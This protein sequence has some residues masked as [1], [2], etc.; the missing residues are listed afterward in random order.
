MK[1]NP[2]HDEF[3]SVYTD[4]QVLEAIRSG[5]DHGQLLLKWFFS[6]VRDYAAGYLSKQYPGLDPAEWDVVFANTNLRLITRVRKGL[7]LQDNTRLATYYTSVARFAALDFIQERKAQQQEIQGEQEPVE[8]PVA[9]QHIEQTERAQLIQDWL[10]RVI[11][12]E[13]QVKVLLLQTKGYSFREIV[14][15][16]A[17]QSEGAC[18]N[19]LGKGKEKVAKYLLDHPKEAAQLRALLQQH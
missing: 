16:T 9:E 10:N 14:A 8:A 13:E 11:G 1:T 12:N 3:G 5:N 15:R 2:F 4:E 18:R 19:A 7:S 6:H 17:Y